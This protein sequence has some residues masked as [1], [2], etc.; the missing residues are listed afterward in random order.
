MDLIKR[1]SSTFWKCN[2]SFDSDVSRWDLEI[3]D[4]FREIL[5]R[6]ILKIIR[7]EK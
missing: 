4:I 2:D 1:R 7:K 6:G 5:I 3:F